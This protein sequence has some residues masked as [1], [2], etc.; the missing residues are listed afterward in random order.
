MSE[1]ELSRVFAALG[2]P[3]RRGIVSSLS[4]G[5]A[6]VGELAEPY[7][8]SMQA[9]S[10]HLRVLENAGLITKTKNAQRRTVHLEAEVFELMTKWIER[11]RR[12]A[13]KRYQRLDA[14]LAAMNAEPSN[15]ASTTKSN[16]KPTARHPAKRRTS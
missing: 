16:T 6:S 2:D 9:I 1:D 11:H 4:A 7:E 10:K 12:E 8:M 15:N 3:T 13:E 14:V 5:D